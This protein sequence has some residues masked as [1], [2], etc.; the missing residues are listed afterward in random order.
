MRTLW[1]VI[2]FLLAVGVSF[3]A[4][5]T[6]NT[7][8]TVPLPAPPCIMVPSLGWPAAIIVSLIAL[9]I[10]AFAVRMSVRASRS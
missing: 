8:C 6:S 5:G 3:L 9:V 7:V 10:A 1:L 4:F 2:A